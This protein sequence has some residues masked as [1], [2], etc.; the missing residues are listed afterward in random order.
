[1]DAWS[2]G[3]TVLELLKFSVS[4]QLAVPWATA[5][6]RQQ[7]RRVDDAEG[8]G[9][10]ATSA[11]APGANNG[12][13]RPELA[14]TLLTPT[15]DADALT[16]VAALLGEPVEELWPGVSTLPGAWATCAHACPACAPAPP[17]HVTCPPPPLP[18]MSPDDAQLV[19]DV[20]ARLPGAAALPPSLPPLGDL[21]CCAAVPT[22]PASTPPRAGATHHAL[23]VARLARWVRLPDLAAAAGWES[24]AVASAASGLDCALRLL[25]FDPSRRLRVADA[26][27]HHPW[28]AAPASTAAG[29]AARAPSPAAALMSPPPASRT[30]AASGH[31]R[32]RD[33]GSSAGGGGGGSGNASAAW[34]RVLAW[35]PAAAAEAAL[36]QQAWDAQRRSAARALADRHAHAAARRRSS[37]GSGGGGGGGEGG[38]LRWR[39]AF[40]LF[41]DDE[42]GAG[43][44]GGGGGGVDDDEHS[45]AS[46]RRPPA[47]LT[48]ALFASADDAQPSAA[49]PATSAAPRLPGGRVLFDDAAGGGRG[50]D[51]AVTAARPSMRPPPASATGATGFLASLKPPS[52]AP[53]TSPVAANLFAAF[54]RG[55]SPAV[56]RS[57]APKSPDSAAWSPPPLRRMTQP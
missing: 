14:A 48:A 15:S 4:S 10:A 44:G 42:G 35:L 20:L 28:L 30:D 12:G 9:G 25:T 39:A 18:P 23:A 17:A 22:T 55:D 43:G 27:A 11:K 2:L 36:K 13:D 41:G 47:S 1:V 40:S 56:A 31:K 3:V 32:R 50:D 29:M 7:R 6:T 21:L 34:D 37:D 16:Q 19:A 53:L 51:A 33:D 49:P 5:A 26:L 54:C 24:P 52:H 45:A 46:P 38:G 8:G 57:G